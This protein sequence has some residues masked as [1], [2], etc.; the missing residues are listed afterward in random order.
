MSLMPAFKIG[1]WN[2]WIL[3]MV[4]LLHPL[5]MGFINKEAFKRIADDPSTANKGFLFGKVILLVAFIYTIF[6]PLKLGTPW[7]YAGLSIYLLGMVMIIVVTM[8]MLTTPLGEP[9]TKGLYRY[10]RHPMYLTFPFY[11]IGIGLAAGSWL[12]FLL[13]TLGGIFHLANA[14]PEERSC[15]EKYG[16]AYREYMDRTPRWLGMPK[17]KPKV[18]SWIIEKEKDKQKAELEDARLN[19]I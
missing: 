1:L 19:S 2:A 18:K 3:M 17:E 11:A 9:F 12:F 7:F 13:F 6:L 4:F 14:I 5:V 16:D 15:L 8:D 10:S